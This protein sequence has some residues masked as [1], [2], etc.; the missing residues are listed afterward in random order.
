MFRK[1][2][3]MINVSN[4]GVIEEVTGFYNCHLPMFSNHFSKIFTLPPNLQSG[5]FA[6]AS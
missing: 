5:I 3:M 6:H 1:I 2:R 4:I